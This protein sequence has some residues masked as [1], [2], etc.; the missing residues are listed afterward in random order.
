MNR[1]T[2]YGLNYP[3]PATSSD[4]TKQGT[5]S[6]ALSYQGFETDNIQNPTYNNCEGLPRLNKYLPPNSK[7]ELQEYQVFPLKNRVME[8][9]DDMGFEEIQNPIVEDIN[10]FKS[11]AQIRNYMTFLYICSELSLSH[12]FREDLKPPILLLKI[13]Y[14]PLSSSVPV[15]RVFP[16]T[17]DGVVG[18]RKNTVITDFDGEYITVGHERP[19]KAQKGDYYLVVNDVCIGSAKETE[20]GV[21]RITVAF[22]GYGKLISNGQCKIM[23]VKYDQFDPNDKKYLDYTLGEKITLNSDVGTYVISLEKCVQG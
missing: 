15:H 19:M 10:S 21:G 20:N 23:N 11:L 6:E 1:S 12:G 3:G 7:V 2:D 5:T 13:T 8:Q 17:E 16:V 14:Y 4:Q 18:S 9:E 22:L